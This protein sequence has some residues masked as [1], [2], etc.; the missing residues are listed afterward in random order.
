MSAVTVQCEHVM[1]CISDVI[2]YSRKLILKGIKNG[3]INFFTNLAIKSS[4]LIPRQI[5]PV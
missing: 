1:C 5:F 2:L 4:N 3:V